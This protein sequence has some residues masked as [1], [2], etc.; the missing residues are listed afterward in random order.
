[1]GKTRKKYNIL[2]LKPGERPLVRPRL[3]LEDNI[4]TYIKEI[5]CGLDSTV[6]V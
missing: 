1:M 6:P 2:V 3:I 4:K 5:G